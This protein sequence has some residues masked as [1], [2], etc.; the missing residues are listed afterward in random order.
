MK[1]I[2]NAVPSYPHLVYSSSS[3]LNVALFN[4]LVRVRVRRPCVPRG[5]PI[6]GRPSDSACRDAARF[7]TASAIN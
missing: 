6:T 7:S 2:A 3:R 1:N 5:R 4:P